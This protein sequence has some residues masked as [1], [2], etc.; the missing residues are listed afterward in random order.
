M[1]TSRLSKYDPYAA[2]LFDHM[3]AQSKPV[4]KIEL[5][6]IVNATAMRLGHSR[7]PDAYRIIYYMRTVL[8][9]HVVVCKGR[10]NAT[11]AIAGSFREASDWITARRKNILSQ[12]KRTEKAMDDTVTEFGSAMSVDEVKDWSVALASIQSAR[13]VISASMM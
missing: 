5:Q 12:I 3:V 7:V 6:V 2:D 4:K 8:G 13:A 1:A 9:P 11:Y 10:R